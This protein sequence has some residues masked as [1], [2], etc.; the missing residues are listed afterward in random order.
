[1]LCHNQANTRESLNNTRKK[2][3]IK[4]NASVR[5]FLNINVVVTYKLEVELPKEISN[6][7]EKNYLSIYYDIGQ[8]FLSE[9]KMYELV[10]TSNMYMGILRL[11]HKVYLDDLI[12]KLIMI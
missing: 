4:Y 1:M 12:N 7:L 8:Y 10:H 5:Y 11:R 3:Y 6:P 9:K 2:K